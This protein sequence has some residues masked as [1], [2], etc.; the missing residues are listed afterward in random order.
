MS[1]LKPSMSA[2]VWRLGDDRHGGVM[3]C[4]RQKG[5][6]RARLPDCA[7]GECF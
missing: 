2:K 5:T 3:H 4:E 7:H 1:N 6:R